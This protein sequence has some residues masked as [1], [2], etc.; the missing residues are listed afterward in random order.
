MGKNIHNRS[1]QLYRPLRANSLQWTAF[2]QSDGP[3]RI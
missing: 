3:I 2:L 1:T